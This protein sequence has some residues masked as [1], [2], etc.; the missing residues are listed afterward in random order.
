MSPSP[1]TFS[2]PDKPASYSWEATDEGVAERYGLPIEQVV[3]FDLNTSPTPP[4]LVAG[5]LAGWR[6]ETGLSEY[7]PG[8]YR[9]LVEAAATR[10]GVGSDEVVPGAGADEILDMCVKAFL[11][12]GATAVVPVPSYAMYR[13]VTE[14]RGGVVRP[15]PRLGPGRG[16]AIDE[17]AVR[18]AAADAALLWLCSPN[19]PTGLPEPAGV[20]ERLL[21]DLEADAAAAGRDPA[22]VVVD[23]AYAEFT[24]ESVIPLRS[25]FANLVVVR[26]ASKAYALAGLRVGFAVAQPATLARV[27]LYRP[28]GSVSTIS[29]TV[30]TRALQDGEE[31]RE[32]VVRVDRE[33]GRLA[34]GLEAAGWPPYPSVTN[35]VLFD[36]GTPAR[37]AAIAERLMRR[38]LVPRTFGPDH[39]LAHCL[40]I[41]VRADHENDRLIDAARAIAEEVSA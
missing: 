26:T 6:F 25:R 17:P 9:R 29:E 2:S 36:L 4:R 39:P 22:A 12:A 37:A 33:R 3:R 40:R 18:A 21:A 41:T 35:F 20:I 24:G 38:G 19:N 32:N 13:V 5:I 8:D 31:M 10:Y 34:A 11:P 30:V 27:A 14:Q 23:E 15:V 16:F 28:P 7:P 1:V